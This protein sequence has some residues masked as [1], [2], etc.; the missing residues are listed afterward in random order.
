MSSSA[1]KGKGKENEKEKGGIMQAGCGL[2][3]AQY[4]GEEQVDLQV[5]MLSYL[6][7]NRVQSVEAPLGIVM[8]FLLVIYVMHC[9]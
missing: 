7:I 6:N 1:A 2:F 5:S 9:L 8:I 3:F 4:P